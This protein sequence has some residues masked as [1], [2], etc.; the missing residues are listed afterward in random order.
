[1]HCSVNDILKEVHSVN[2]VSRRALAL[3]DGDANEICSSSHQ[4]M[5]V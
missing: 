5:R 1:M 3:C 2:Y 4:K